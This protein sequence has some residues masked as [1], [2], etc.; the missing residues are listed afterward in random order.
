MNDNSPPTIEKTATEARQGV[1][2]G[3]VRWV[4]VIST[5]GAVVGLAVAFWLVHGV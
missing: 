3:I 2:P 4:L 5:C 1:T